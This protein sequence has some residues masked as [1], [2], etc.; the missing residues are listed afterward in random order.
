MVKKRKIAYVSGT[1]ADYGLMTSILKAID[2]SDKLELLLYVTGI[3]L[4]P[5]FGETAKEVEKEFSQTKRLP[6]VFE[7]DDR[8]G[9]AKFTGEFLQKLVM[10]FNKNRPDFVLTLGDRPEMLMVASACLYL[11]IPTG[12]IS[13]GDRTFTVD[14]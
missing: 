11:G 7:S 5:K 9:M 1:R 10:E 14:E 6:A 2:K 12:Q 4:M 3:H 8:L 13:G